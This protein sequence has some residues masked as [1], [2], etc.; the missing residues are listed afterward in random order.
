MASKSVGLP[1]GSPPPVRAA[2]ST[3]LMSLANSLPR[4]ASSAAFLCLVVAHFEWPDVYYLPSSSDGRSILPVL[5]RDELTR[6]VGVEPMVPRHLGMEGRGQQV[7][8]AHRHR[9]CRVVPLHAREHRDLG[10]PVL[11]P[12]GPDEHGSD[13]FRSELS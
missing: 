7:T 8:L 6:E 2:T 9:V 10:S 12:W 1:D 4:L 5:A 3:F 13:G 11:D